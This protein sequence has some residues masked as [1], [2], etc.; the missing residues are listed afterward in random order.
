MM[1]TVAELVKRMR[2]EFLDDPAAE[3][4]SDNGWKTPMLVAGLNA[5]QEEITRR[6]LCIT[7]AST[8]A[9]GGIP[10]CSLTIA[11]VAGVFA[12]SWTVSRKII[13]IN[14]LFYPGV[15]LPLKQRSRLYLDQFDPGWL[16]KSGTPTEFCT[17]YETGKITFNRVPT[18]AGTV[19]M[20]VFRLPLARLSATSAGLQA[21]PELQEM[22]DQLIYG[23]LKWSYV[24]DDNHVQD[25]KAAD[26]WSNAFEASLSLL[27]VNKAH[28]SPQAWVTRGSI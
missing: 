5:A 2:E 6:L 14:Q 26:R 28:L 18:A 21:S 20:N 1:P 4:E 17:D 16:G 9:V 8:A 19:T 7:D 12:Q 23:G 25:K 22:D 24:L 10:L 13:K 15:R 27:T 3:D 11:A